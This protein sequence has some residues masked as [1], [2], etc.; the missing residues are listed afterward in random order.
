M[1]A[2]TAG[3]VLAGGRAARMGGGDKCRIVVGGV[4]VITRIRAAIGPQ[5]AALALGANGNPA[6]FGDLGLPVLPDSMPG[7]PGPL[8]GV[9]A[10]LD[11]AAGLDLP[12][13]LSVPGDA[14]FLPEDL[15]ARL[16][17]ARGD[18]DYAC[19]ASAGPVLH[20]VVA[21]WPV[22]CRG[23]MRAA[24]AAGLRKVRGFAVQAVAAWPA[25]AVDPF[26]NLNAPG[27]VRPFR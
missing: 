25:G 11:W 5:V 4:P 12:W 24:L 2:Q 3:V 8:A 10:G 6:R 21:L 14:P 15:V 9:L 17:Q 16:H 20:P 7:Q 18:G 13:L 23:P 22:S 1:R 19:A 27:D 26:T